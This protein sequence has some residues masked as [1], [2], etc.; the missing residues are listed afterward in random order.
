MPDTV[1]LSQQRGRASGVSY[2]AAALAALLLPLFGSCSWD[3]DSW[4]PPNGLGD[5]GAVIP[6]TGGP[7][8]EIVLHYV[9][10]SA[11]LLA[12]AYRDLFGVLS[13]DVA[14]QIL[15]PSVE[16]SE[17]FL[18]EWADLARTG[19]RRIQVV[20]CAGPLTIWARDRRVA[21]QDV[22]TGL[23]RTTYVPPAIPDY[24]EDKRH[25]LAIPWYLANHVLGP[26][27]LVSRIHLEGGNIVSNQRHAFVGAN[28]LSE[29]LRALP[30]AVHLNRELVRLLGRDYLVLGDTQDNVPF[31]HADMY[32]TPVD[33][34]TVLVADPRLA[35]RLL[36]GHD[37]SAAG[38]PDGSTPEAPAPTLDHGADLLDQ[39]SEA[40]TQRGYVVLRL[41]AVIDPDENWMVS[42]NNV[43]MER[44]DGRGIVY[45]SAYRVPRLDE[46]AFETYQRLGFEVHPVDVS[47]VYEYGGGVRC[48]ANVIRRRPPRRAMPRSAVV[49]MSELSRRCHSRLRGET[50]I[51][52]RHASEAQ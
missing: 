41:P 31:C 45:M 49:A 12:P 6:D 44:R 36:L 20:N 30:S 22:L 29:N 28:V 42:Y 11:E 17:E 50:S 46:A 21:R 40:L 14:L 26:G 34:Q 10:E 3:V 13:S 8:A 15:C 38:Q 48:L 7:I 5:D 23:P 19:G 39:I 2:Q 33:E 27:V 51:I 1:L 37:S 32:V 35:K 24:D 16:A 4:D 52:R 47:L 9:P 25:E 18:D 43:L